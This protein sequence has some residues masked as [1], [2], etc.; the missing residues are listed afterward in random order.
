MKMIALKT[1]FKNV[2]I[3]RRVTWPLLDSDPQLP[4]IDIRQKCRQRVS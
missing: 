4:L 1:D 3:V 2:I